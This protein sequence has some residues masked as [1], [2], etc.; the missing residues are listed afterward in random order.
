MGIPFASI[1]ASEIAVSFRV[2][3]RL[4]V[5]VSWGLFRSCVSCVS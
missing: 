5:Y 4:A 3:G 1:H 2:V